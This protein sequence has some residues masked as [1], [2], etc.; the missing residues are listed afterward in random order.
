MWKEL[1]QVWRSSDLLSLAWEESYRMLEI[2]ERMFTEAVRVLRESDDCL[3]DEAIRKLDTRVNKYERDVRRKVMT[4]CTL[5]GPTDIPGGMV[6]VSIVIDIERIGDYCKN[7]LDLAAAHPQKLNIDSY[8][9]VL[10]EIE[11]EI[12]DCFQQ[13]PKILRSHDAEQARQVML[14][15]RAQVSDTCDQIV[16]DVVTGKLDDKSASEAA[17]LALYARYLKRISAHLKNVLS[18]VVNPFHRIGYKEKRKN[19]AT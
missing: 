11:R 8:N 16:E 15:Y 17:T 5:A 3:V 18:S 6:L 13:A 9:D 10:S 19:N 1:L 2:D 12:K 14:T 4:H 7:I